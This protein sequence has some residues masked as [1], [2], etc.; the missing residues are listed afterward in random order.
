[1]QS[2][3]HNLDRASW[4]MREQAPVKCH[5]LGGRSTMVE[6]IYG[7]VFDHHSVVYEFANGVRMY[8]LLPH[9]DRL[10]R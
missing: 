5:G 3:V 8:A 4:V 2:L 10:L 9:D 7:N 6:P 1:M